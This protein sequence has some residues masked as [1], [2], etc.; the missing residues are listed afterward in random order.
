MIKDLNAKLEAKLITPASFLKQA[1][2]KNPK[3]T[4]QFFTFDQ[5]GE[6]DIDDEFP[7]ESDDDFA[8]PLS[9]F[10][11]NEFATSSSQASCDSSAYG[12]ASQCSLPDLNKTLDTDDKT[13][14]GI[15]FINP[16]D[17][18]LVPCGQLV[19]FSCWTFW[20]GLHPEKKPISK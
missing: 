19:C 9:Q 16:K 3:L 12:T 8:A 4:D 6:L 7:I 13:L 5:V 11:S 2:W 10:S 14:C 1:A 15:C 20:V 18:I 17:L